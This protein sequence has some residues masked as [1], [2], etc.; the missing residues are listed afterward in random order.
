MRKF[1]PIGLMAVITVISCQ[2]VDMNMNNGGYGRSASH[3]YVDLGLPSGLKWAT[4]NLGASAPEQ[5]GDY[6]AWG[7][8]EPYYST[9]SPVSWKDGKSAGYD[10]TSYRW[11]IGPDDSLTKYCTVYS[12]GYSD[13]KTV[14]EMIDDAAH[15]KWGGKWRMP[16][17]NEWQELIN[18]CKWSWTTRN[19][20]QGMLGISNI[21]G[22]SIFLPAAGGRYGTDLNY[23]GSNGY[24]WSSSLCTDYPYCACYFYFNSDY[25]DRDFYSRFDG[26]SI[27][28]V[29]K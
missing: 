1:L 2:T 9:Q 14:L 16:A 21:N 28:P 22:N 20:R 29:T 18:Y 17:I 4:C 25:V 27:R 6:Y 11:C 15:V 7:E 23:T 5:Y 19:G 26:L 13:N 8:T 12:Y 24:Y 10:W 3:E